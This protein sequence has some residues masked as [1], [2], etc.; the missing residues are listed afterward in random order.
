MI[1]SN[2]LL[3]STIATAPIPEFVIAKIA[4]EIDFSAVIAT[5][6][7]CFSTNCCTVI[8]HIW[9]RFPPG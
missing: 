4:S 5:F 9:P 8:K 7:L 3:L 6:L 2:T 1:P